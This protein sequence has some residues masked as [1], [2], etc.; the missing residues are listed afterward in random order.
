MAPQPERRYQMSKSHERKLVRETLDRVGKN[1]SKASSTNA[2]LISRLKNIAQYMA[3]NQGLNSI[4]H[5]KTR[6]VDAYVA[7]L[8]DER[9]LAPSSLQGYATA[10]RQLAN[11]IGKSNIIRSNIELGA[12]RSNADRYKNANTPSDTAKLTEIRDGLYAR[13]EWQGLA[14]EMQQLFGLR[15][16]ESLGSVNTI[17]RDGRFF[18]HVPRGFA[19][20]GLER[21]VPVESG[22]QRDLLDRV[23]AHCHNE[24]QRSL[25]PA[26]KSLKQGYW[27][28]VNAI[29]DLGGTKKNNA[30]SH[31]L[32]R[33]YIRERY[34]EIREIPDREQR[35]EAEQ[36]LIEQVG[37]FDT[38]KLRHYTPK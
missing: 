9:H 31:S 18:L 7:H 28:Q 11:T 37:H 22:A 32:R 14:H 30:N 3:T 1:W 26:A 36:G 16:K 29:R 23:Q 38:E 2:K 17:E 24:G 35:Q 34:A 4:T 12:N 20:N 25:I 8:R 13:A 21:L 6:H 10:M 19:K 5:M 27:Q 15:I 33:E